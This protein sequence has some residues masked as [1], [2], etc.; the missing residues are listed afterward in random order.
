METN[1]WSQLNISVVGPSI[2]GSNP[3]A[4]GQM[5]AGGH[6]A[7][8]Q[9]NNTVNTLSAVN[10]PNLP[11]PRDRHVAGKWYPSINLFSGS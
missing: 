11:S 1:T 6:P 9:V 10:D 2:P 5:A 3:A 8:T 7:G 4:G